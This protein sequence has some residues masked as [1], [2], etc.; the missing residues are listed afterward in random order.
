M[1]L[2][3]KQ[4]V[5]PSSVATF[6]TKHAKDTSTI[7]ALSPAQPKIFE[8]EQAITFDGASEAEI[9][10]EGAAAGSYEQPTPHVTSKRFEVV[11]TT[12]VSDN[13]VYADEDNA[14]QI[15]SNIQADQ[16]A[17]L[18]RAL[19]Y[20]VYHNIQPK[21]GSK[22]TGWDNALA[23]HALKAYL[24]AALSGATDDQMIS[25]FDNMADLVSDEYDINGIAMAKSYAAR[26]RRIRV[27]N[28]QQRMFPDIP[29]N[30]AVGNFEGVPASV[31]G[32]VNG[33][34]AATA[35]NVLAFLG[36][37]SLIKWGMVRSATAEV[38]PYGDPDGKGDL[39]NRRQV[40][41]RTRATY[42]YTVLDANAFAVLLAMAK[43]SD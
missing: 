6:V 28:T 27:K 26:L 19:D 39:K 22:L 25:S 8:D 34:V 32:T 38:I 12:R 35:T 16:T 2:E 33:R 4:I 30:L 14:L 18:G 42:A 20:A 43:P 7:A 29:L 10:E 21:D 11:T 36:D 5:L 37:Y 31:S 13:L 3:T 15:V 9:V 17:A 41:Y 23:D 1:A 40:A 24:G